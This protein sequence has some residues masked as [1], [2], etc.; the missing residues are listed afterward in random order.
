MSWARLL[1]RVFEIDIEHCPQC[2]G[3]LKII[4]A[5]EH[6]PVI[7]KSLPISVWPPEHRPE[8]QPGPSIPTGLI[9][10]IPLPFGSAPAPTLPLGA[11]SP[12]RE[13]APKHSAPG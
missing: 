8:Q 1:K 5:I 4:A 12:K 13:N 2:G 7:T 10:P 9:P 6:P 3:A 11:R